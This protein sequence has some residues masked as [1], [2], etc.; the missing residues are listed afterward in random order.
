MC[1]PFRWHAYDMIMASG[2]AAIAAAITAISRQT[3]QLPIMDKNSVNAPSVVTMAIMPIAATAAIT[4]AIA[5]ITAIAMEAEITPKTLKSYQNR[6]FA[7]FVR[8]LD[9]MPNIATNSRNS[10]SLEKRHKPIT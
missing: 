8:E 6:G 4:A 9:I 10:T 3:W 7:P 1:A 2:I 5:A